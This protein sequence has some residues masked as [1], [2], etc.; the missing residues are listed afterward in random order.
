MFGVFYRR[1]VALPSW[2]VRLVYPSQ[3]VS[4]F[5]TAC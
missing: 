5:T 2:R 1:L 4:E 3:A